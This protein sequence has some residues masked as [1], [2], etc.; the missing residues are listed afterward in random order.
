MAK[1]TL[2]NDL[3][4][5]RALLR[6]LETD[7]AG[8]ERM[9]ASAALK[10]GMRTRIRAVREQ[11]AREEDFARKRAERAAARRTVSDEPRR[12]CGSSDKHLARRVL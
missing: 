4:V 3:R 1:T 9:T 8:F 11:I 7:L 2:P 5:L 10:E 12:R 6:T